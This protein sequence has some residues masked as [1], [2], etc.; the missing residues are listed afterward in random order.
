[1]STTQYYPTDLT[2]AQGTLLGALLPPRQWRPGGP[3]RPPCDLRCVLNGILYLLIAVLKWERPDS[4]NA[5][6]TPECRARRSRQR[7]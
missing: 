7:Q 1:M 6:T 4:H 3:G 2:E 5:Q